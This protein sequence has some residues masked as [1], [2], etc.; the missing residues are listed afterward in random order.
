MNSDVQ[1]NELVNY[2]HQASPQL[3]DLISARAD[4]DLRDELVPG[5]TASAKSLVAFES[6][7]V[8]TTQILD[9]I[10]ADASS[11]INKSQRQLHLYRQAR[12]GGELFSVVSALVTALLTFWKSG[13]APVAAVISFAS[14]LITLF[15]EHAVRFAPGDRVSLLQLYEKLTAARFDAIQARQDIAL[16]VA[17]K[18]ETEGK[19]AI[20]KANL[21]AR[22]MNIL[23]SHPLFA[24]QLAG[25]TL[26]NAGGMGL[27]SKICQ[28][29]S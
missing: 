17:S 14:S 5:G 10:I 11:V 20:K 8:V 16:S 28:K 18:S 6:R 22:E 21:A 4:A 9:E 23:L 24:A 12:F 25:R 2:L 3:L 13:G 7:A 27:G 29:P 26:V 15:A 19:S 1:I